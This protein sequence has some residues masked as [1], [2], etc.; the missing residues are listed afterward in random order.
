IG[1]PAYMSPEQCMGRSDLDHRTDLYSL[2]CVFY[3][4]LCGRPPFVSDQGT[5]MI[6]AAHMRDAVEDPRAISASV[7]A[8][9]AAITMRLLEKEPAKRFQ[10]AAELRSALVDAGA[11][12]PPTKPPAATGPSASSGYE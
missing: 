11:A 1:T 5:G 3:H 12:S 6:L 7:P 8:P 4:L 9:L 2:G 10:T